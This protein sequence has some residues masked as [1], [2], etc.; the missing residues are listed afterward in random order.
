M[1][2]LNTA[3]M[4]E[5]DRRTIDEVGIPSSVLM[6]NAGRQVVAAME[7]QFPSLASLRVTVICGK[8]NNGGDGFVVARVLQARGVETR[9][10]VPVAL[11]EVTGD[12]RGNLSAL[13]AL[14]VPVLDVATPDA[15]A[16]HLAEITA[17]G[18]IVDA[19]FGTGLSRPL[20]DRWRAVV[21]DLNACDAP[22]VSIDLPSGLS[23]DNASL[24]GET[25]E[26]QL[27]V[28]FGA[29][30][31]P[32]IVP[33]AATQAGD[34]VV[35][36]I[37]IPD[38][39]IDTLA[40]PRLEVMTRE[41]AQDL[42]VPRADEIHKGDCGRVL[43]VAGSPGKTGAARLAALGALRSGAGLVTVATPRGCQP[44]V[45]GFMPEYMTLGLDETEDGLVT[46][47]AA[48]AVLAQRCDVIA[49]GPG[50]GEGDGPRAF[51]H[52]LLR[53]ATTPLV[54]D[55]DALNACAGDPSL[56]AGRDGR[57]LIITPHPGEMAR[58]TGTTVDHVQTHR[59]EVARDLAT[60]Q[61]IYVVLKGARTVV[62]TPAGVVWVN[63]TG[64]PGMATGGTGDVLTGVVAAWLAQLLDADAACTL[65][66]FLHGMAGDLAADRHGEVALIATDVADH[67]GPALL[68]LDR[69]DDEDGGPDW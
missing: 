32:L 33:P 26:A 27:T 21:A 65:G 46:A 66:V 45:S 6:E 51:V 18:I 62:A 4:R 54:L 8:G 40:G 14:G 15:W 1:R 17:S 67:L 5:A 55:A 36:D 57:D 50:L 7:R 38:A 2:I 34:V 12:A 60:A 30:K 20:Q 23:A 43:I 47:E 69:D 59:I 52:A 42:V 53:T 31:I 39:V 9:V 29:P 44:V 3:Q 35:A 41:W 61:Q 25:I 49:V 68:D 22:I 48:A 13:D 24:I 64:N 11:A 10:Y 19:L 58:L 37:G 63:L 28:T 16:A 56:L